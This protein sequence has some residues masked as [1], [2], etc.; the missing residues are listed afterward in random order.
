[1]KVKSM[2]SAD[3]RENI[4]N[5]TEQLL[6]R[7]GYRK[8]TMEDVAREAGIGKGTTYLYFPSKEELVLS[9]IDRLVD[10]MSGELSRI[11]ESGSSP[12]IRLQQ[13]LVSRVM[14]RFDRVQDYSAGLNDVLAAIRSNLLKRRENYF[15]QEAKILIE[16]LREGLDTGELRF[17]DSP[18]TVARTLLLATNSLL[19]Y[20]LSTREL[21]ERE[22]IEKKANQIAE[23]LLYGISAAE[24]SQL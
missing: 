20:S 5:A 23:L 4:L 22:D 16:V 9:T 14:F 11:A 21:G 19:P 18:E 24:K 12:I 15:S 7:Y 8:M 13:M 1:M 10:D 17:K 2:S 6:S 3:V